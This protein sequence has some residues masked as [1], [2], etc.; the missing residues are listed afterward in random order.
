MVIYLKSDTQTKD[1]LHGELVVTRETK[2]T[3]S[4][5]EGSLQQ[6]TLGNFF[7]SHATCKVY[8]IGQN[9]NEK[10]QTINL[11]EKP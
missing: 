9:L 5:R 1:R 3:G 7:H 8:R 10:P 4:W 11:K 2:V 6:G